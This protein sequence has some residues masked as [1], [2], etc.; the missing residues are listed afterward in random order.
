MADRTQ[1]AYLD[2]EP[3]IAAMERASEA[4]NA[5]FVAGNMARLGTLIGQV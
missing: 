2:G 4:G 5:D 3:F 1:I